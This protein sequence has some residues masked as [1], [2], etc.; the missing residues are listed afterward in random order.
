MRLTRLFLNGSTIEEGKKI[1]ITPKQ[2]HYLSTVMRLQTGSQVSVFNGKNGEWLAKFE[3]DSLIPHTQTRP[4]STNYRYELNL[5]FALPKHKAL[6]E[7]VRQATELDV[8]TLRPIYSSRTENKFVDITKLE[9]LAIEAA[10][11][12]RRMD[13][14]ICLPPI[15]IEEV[16][17]HYKNAFICDESLSGSV[18]CDIPLLDS[19]TIV[20]GPEGGFSHEELALIQKRISLGKTT[21]R[22]DTAVVSAIAQVRAIHCHL[23]RSLK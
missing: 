9:L 17:K 16:E 14:P 12:C 13:A 19:Y 15:S 11:Q 6:K 22:C 2:Q 10:Q 3:K 20:I 23:T 1:S 21:L 7:I 5:C 18:V 8:S 4:Q